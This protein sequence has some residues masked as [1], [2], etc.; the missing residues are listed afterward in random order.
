MA[1]RPVHVYNRGNNA[2][3]QWCMINNPM[4]ACS[5]LQWEEHNDH[6]TAGTRVPPHYSPLLRGWAHYVSRGRLCGARLPRKGHRIYVWYVCTGEISF[7]S[8]QKC[9]SSEFLKFRHAISL[10][11]TSLW[12]WLSIFF[13]TP[14]LH[15]YCTM[16]DSSIQ[17]KANH[18]V[19][20]T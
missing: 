5:R 20:N 11:T 1:S 6:R 15:C 19:S 16:E 12:R 10:T 3:F 4:F 13:V 17:E 14:Y 7:V 8:Y 9:Q 18:T 2:T